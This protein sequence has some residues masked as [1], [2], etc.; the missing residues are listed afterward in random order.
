[1]NEPKLVERGSGSAEDLCHWVWTTGSLK[2]NREVSLWQQDSFWP[3]S[4][5]QLDILEAPAIAIIRVGGMLKDSL[6]SP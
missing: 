2:H 3:D 1:M 4:V 5:L 6:Q